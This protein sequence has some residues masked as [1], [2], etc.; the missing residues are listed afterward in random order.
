MHR[1]HTT[2]WDFLQTI[3]GWLVAN[4]E[5]ILI[6]LTPLLAPL[7]SMFAAIRALEHAGWQHANLIGAIVE[8]M[9]LAAGAFMGH[10][11]AHNHRHP[12]NQIS[13]WWGRGLFA[14]YFVV[15]E[16]LILSSDPNIVSA[17]LPGLTLVGSVIV[18]FRNLMRRADERQ[19]EI[20]AQQQTET[21]IERQH[22]QA[23]FDLQ[24]E[25]KRREAEQ[26]L[27]AQQAEH[28]QKLDLERQKAAARLSKTVQKSV[29]T[30][31][32]VDTSI[33]GGQTVDTENQANELDKLLDIY[34]DKPKA[35]LRFV[36]SKLGKSPQTISN[37]LE[38]LEDDGIIHRNGSGVEILG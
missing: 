38:R 33:T 4:V 24:L 5:A 32:Q 20:E 15:V 3:A 17:L 34:R 12:D 37:W 14:F 22:D 8:A 18:G 10:V 19:A 28:A 1:N 16:A 36:G 7:P 23:E 6:M 9:G 31:V 13:K 35:S 11:E 30:S 27:A 25:I 26:R 2:R 21:E 29:Q